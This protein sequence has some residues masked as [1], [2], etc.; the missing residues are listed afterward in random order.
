MRARYA[1]RQ[2]AGERQLS[3]TNPEQ[4]YQLMGPELDPL[5]QEQVWAL[6]LSAVAGQRVLAGGAAG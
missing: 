4:V 5:M 2:P 1:A 6:L 3:I